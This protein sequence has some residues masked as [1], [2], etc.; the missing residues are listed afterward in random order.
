LVQRKNFESYKSQNKTKY[1]GKGNFDGKNK[2]SHPTNFKKKT[3]KKKRVC[4]VC[5]DPDHWAPN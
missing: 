5:G 3:D 4:P 2:D 1:D